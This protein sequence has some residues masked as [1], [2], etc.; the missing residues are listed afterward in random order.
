ML[1]GVCFLTLNAT[2]GLGFMLTMTISSPATAAD[3]VLLHAAGSLRGALT[4]VT[5]AFTKTYGAPVIPRFGASGL[6]KDVIAA[7]EKAEVYASANM[8]HPQ[9]LQREGISGPV[10]LFARNELCAFLRPGLA[11]T[12]ADLLDKM[13]DPAVK[14]GTSTPRADPAGDYA[15]AVFARAEAVKAGAKAALE[16]K[17]LQLTGGPNSPPTPADRNVYG[18]RLAQGA[19]DIFLAY[20]TNA[21]P[22]AKEQ[23]A[24]RMLRL[25]EAL[26]VGA[27]YGLTV[28]RGASPNAYR[29]AMFILSADGQR[30][31]ARQG[32]SAPALPKEGM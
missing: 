19:A 24:V 14:L 23:P 8:D 12:S 26:A 18:E 3:P 13:L 16:T 21:G 25:P 31:L 22:I 4:E 5:Q 11:A 6:L 7:G 20:C 1:Q 30:I 29:L 9:A 10:V 2:L 15:F 32:F 27:D 28:I 17:A